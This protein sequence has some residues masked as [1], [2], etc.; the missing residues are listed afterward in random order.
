[1]LGPVSRRCE[2]RDPHVADADRGPVRHRLVLEPDPGLRRHVD[3]RAGRLL[4]AALPGDVVG[5]VVGLEDVRD[6]EAVFVGEL[7]V[8]LD[9]P[10]GVDHRRLSSVGDHVRGAAEVFVQDLA[11]EH[12]ANDRWYGA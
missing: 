6:L 7:E 5:V 11:E 1:V 9:V 2:R 3:R 4:Q 10:L 8:L 12:A